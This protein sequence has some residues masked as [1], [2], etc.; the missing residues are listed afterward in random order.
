MKERRIYYPM[1]EATRETMELYID[2]MLRACVTVQEAAEAIG[3]ALH[4]IF[5]CE[6]DQF[7]AFNDA[8]KA[9]K[10]TEH[11]EPFERPKQAKAPRPNPCPDAG[12]LRPPKSTRTAYAA[13]VQRIRPQA[14]SAIKQRRN[15]RRE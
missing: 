13:R 8:L 11:V 4:K 9:V 10:A 14:R 12:P 6:A 15:R 5:D 3:K 2:A 7:E 1:G